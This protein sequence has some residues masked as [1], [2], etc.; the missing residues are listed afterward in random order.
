MRTEQQR[1][2]A[3]A[4]RV[5]LHQ[6]DVVPD[7]ILF[8]WGG[9]DGRDGKQTLTVHYDVGGTGAVVQHRHHYLI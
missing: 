4:E 6:C 5:M 2:V 3:L 7:S 1:L 9:Y 8:E